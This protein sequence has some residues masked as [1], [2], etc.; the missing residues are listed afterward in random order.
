MGLI[1]T[2]EKI[3]NYPADLFGIDYVEHPLEYGEYDPSVTT[4]S[5]PG[6]R[7]TQTFSCGYVAGMMVLHTFYPRRSKTAFWNKVLPDREFGVQTERLTK[8][9][10]QSNLKVT[11]RKKLTFDEIAANIEASRP[12]I[13]EVKSRFADSHWVV[14]YGIGRSP[15]RIFIAGCG[16]PHFSSCVRSW[17]EYRRDRTPSGD[18]LICR[19]K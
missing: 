19:A 7:Q 9:L 10:R 15:K 16:L 11:L 18:Y 1:E 14:I 12:I 4:L 13:A 2:F 5:V 17:A 3:I 6:Y 8:A